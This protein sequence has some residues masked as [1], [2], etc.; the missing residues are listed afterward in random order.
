MS[1]ADRYFI[2]KGFSK[3]I[4]QGIEEFTDDDGNYIHFDL[5]IER[6]TCNCYLSAKEL[7]AI[8]KKVEELRMD[9]SNKTSDKNVA[10]IED[11]IEILES[12]VKVHNDFL[13]GVNKES[14]NEKEIRALERVLLHYKNMKFNYENL[15]H[16]ISLIAESLDM[17]EDSTIEE[18]AIRISE[19]MYN[20]QQ[21][22]KRIQELEEYISI[23]PNLNE[24]TATKYITIQQ[25][26]YIRGKAEEQRRA[27]QII[28]ENYIPKQAVI[29]TINENGFEV[30]TREY[31]NIEVVSIDVLQELLEGEK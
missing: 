10:N 29:D 4:K 9:M 12:I 18:I 20:Q 25:E 6:F 22:D 15:I 26:A 23:A 1:E 11:D 13:Q 5:V 14:I 17:Q 31:G 3:V 28:Y 24:M 21:K 30:Y 27:E 7:Q 16:D 8:N 19:E 2:K